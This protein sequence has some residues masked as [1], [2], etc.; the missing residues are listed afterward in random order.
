MQDLWLAFMR[1]PVNGLPSQGWDAYVP[2]G[3]AIELAWNE[4]VTG[5]IALSK[6]DE[7]CEGTTPIPG[8]VPPD[9]V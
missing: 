8:A 1:D 7:N 9:H 3:N 4:K 5:S 6:F 2:G